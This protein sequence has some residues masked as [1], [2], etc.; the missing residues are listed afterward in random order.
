VITRSEMTVIDTEYI[1]EEG[2]CILELFQIVFIFLKIIPQFSG[3]AI[4]YWVMEKAS[5]AEFIIRIING[6]IKTRKTRDVTNS[7]PNSF[8]FFI[9]TSPPLFSYLCLPE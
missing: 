7:R 6:N 3:R 8:L 9:I 5:L 2:Y 4:G 1:K